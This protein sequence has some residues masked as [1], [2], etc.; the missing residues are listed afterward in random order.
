MA[1]EG[2]KYSMDVSTSIVDVKKFFNPRKKMTIKRKSDYHVI[3][4]QYPWDG[5]AITLYKL[6]TLKGMH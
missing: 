5:V 6:L 4:L 3:D 2:T 1:N